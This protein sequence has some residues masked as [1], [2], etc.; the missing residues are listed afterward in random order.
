MCS[1]CGR[2]F[3]QQEVDSKEFREWNK[4]RREKEKKKAINEYNREWVLQNKDKM[5]IYSKRYYEKNKNRISAKMKEHRRI[6]K[7]SHDDNSAGVDVVE[8][9]KYTKFISLVK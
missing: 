6:K 1:K 4:K 9:S 3:L 7:I 8:T 2:L 5:K